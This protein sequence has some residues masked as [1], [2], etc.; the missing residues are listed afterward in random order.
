M[1]EASVHP[2]EQWLRDFTLQNYEKQT[3]ELLGKQT[4]ALFQQWC[5]DNNKTFNISA[6]KLGMHLSNM[7]ING[8]IKGRHTKNGE[9][10]IFNVD[11]LKTYFKIGL[12]VQ[13]KDESTVN[14]RIENE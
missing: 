11:V 3:V 8:I 12:L 13:L 6:D 7:R 14:D 9:T 2:I 4:L 5:L 1:K 10:K